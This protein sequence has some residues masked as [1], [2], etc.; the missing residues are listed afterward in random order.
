MSLDMHCPE[1]ST[2]TFHFF[3]SAGKLDKVA[4]LKAICAGF[5]ETTEPAICLSEGLYLPNFLTYCSLYSSA[6]NS[7]YG[8]VEWWVVMVSKCLSLVVL[9]D[10]TFHRVLMSSS[11]TN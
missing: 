5:Q 4:V 8:W 7:M 11:P 2:L 6:I 3:G 9:F 10:I 1:Y